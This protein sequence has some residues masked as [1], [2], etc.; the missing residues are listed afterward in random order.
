MEHCFDQDSILTQ[1]ELELHIFDGQ[2]S[3][4]FVSVFEKQLLDLCLNQTII[5]TPEVWMALSKVALGDVR[6]KYSKISILANS[7]DKSSMRIALDDKYL[8]IF[9]NPNP[10]IP[11]RFFINLCEYIWPK[12]ISDFPNPNIDAIILKRLSEKALY[13]EVFEGYLGYAASSSHP[14]W[15]WKIWND[16]RDRFDPTPTEFLLSGYPVCNPD[17][18]KP[19]YDFLIRL[20]SNYYLLTPEIADRLLKMEVSKNTRDQIAAN[21]A[22]FSVSGVSRKFLL[23][24]YTDEI[25]T[26]RFRDFE[27]GSR[28]P[29]FD[30][31][32]EKYPF[33]INSIGRIDEVQ[34][35]LAKSKVDTQTVPHEKTA[36]IGGALSILRDDTLPSGIYELVDIYREFSVADLAIKIQSEIDKK[37][38]KWHQYL[39]ARLKPKPNQFEKEFETIMASLDFS[40][41]SPGLN[42]VPW[43]LM[44]SEL[45][46]KTVTAVIKQGYMTP[47]E[48][49]LELITELQH[50]QTKLAIIYEKISGFDVEAVLNAKGEITPEQLQEV[51]KQLESESELLSDLDLSSMQDLFQTI[52]P[53]AQIPLDVDSGDWLLESVQ[54]SDEQIHDQQLLDLDKRRKKVLTLVN[55][56]PALKFKFEEISKNSHNFSPVCNQFLEYIATTLASIHQINI[57]YNQYNL[58]SEGQKISESEKSKVKASQQKVFET[59]LIPRLIQQYQQIIEQINIF[60]LALPVEINNNPESEQ[61]KALKFIQNI[62]KQKL[63]SIDNYLKLL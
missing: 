26:E 13:P 45:K 58:L 4:G 10:T 63:H 7:D 21:I 54:E 60:K 19:F 14:A 39:P 29:I 36:K 56:N 40:Y 42:G 33:F 16:Q 6:S 1:K 46:N 12:P 38:N 49:P 44:Y 30:G 41:I 51:L 48:Y 8:E 62:A 50:L 28:K 24:N 37:T 2:F 52:H 27:N 15:K 25:T 57:Y 34:Y 43:Q 20:S 17:L 47:G 5:L 3:P 31:L 55:I 35:A 18:K 59:K 22:N 9:S 23:Y 32:V 53:G 11:P 61:I